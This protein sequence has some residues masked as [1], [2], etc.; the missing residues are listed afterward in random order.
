L[1]SHSLW[2]WLSSDR[3]RKTLFKNKIEGKEKEKK[4]EKIIENA[5]IQTT[6]FKQAVHFT[7]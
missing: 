4:T 1:R 2:L 6:L 5:E 3:K 7:A